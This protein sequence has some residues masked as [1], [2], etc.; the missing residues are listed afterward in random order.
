[1]ARVLLVDD[2]RAA[3]DLRQ[4]ILER[5]GHQ[6]S[7]ASDAAHA[8]ALFAQTEP[9][10]AILDLRLPEAADGLA[11]IRDLRAAAPGVRIIVLSGWPLDLEGTPEAEMVDLVLAK[12]I[13]TATLIAVLGNDALGNL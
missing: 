4:L 12:P 10:I 7:A 6:V 1:M 9:E 8:R 11:L 2:D 3:L 13:R 5:E